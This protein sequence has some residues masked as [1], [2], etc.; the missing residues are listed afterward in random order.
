MGTGFPSGVIKS[1]NE[2]GD[3]RAMLCTSSILN[4]AL[5]ND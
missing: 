3:G 4:R 5:S 2:T 1:W